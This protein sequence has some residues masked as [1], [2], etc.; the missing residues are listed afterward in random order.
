MAQVAVYD[1]TLSKTLYMEPVDA[2]FA[3]TKY[4]ARY[5]FPT[6]VL[7]PNSSGTPYTVT[8]ISSA[9]PFENTAKI[10]Y[11]L[12][13]YGGT[14]SKVEHSRDGVTYLQ[15]GSATG[16]TMPWRSGDWAKITYSVAPTVVAVP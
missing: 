10:D 11:F 12:H 15:L 8:G 14:V 6:P 2:S 13:I 9:T 3:V 7:N 4:P 16:V 1:A 5:S